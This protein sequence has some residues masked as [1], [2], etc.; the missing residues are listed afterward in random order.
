MI[1]QFFVLSSR[2]DKIISREC[3][4]S[5]KFIVREDIIRGSEEIF[6][7]NTK[8]NDAD[9]EPCFVNIILI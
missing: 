2:G 4:I 6:F 9:I 7:R 8:N 1:S 5:I 3:N